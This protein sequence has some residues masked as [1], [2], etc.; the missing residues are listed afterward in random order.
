MELD[1][2]NYKDYI[3]SKM[4]P[5]SLRIHTTL[6]NAVTDDQDSDYGILAN[7][8]CISWNL[9][10]NNS[11]KFDPEDSTTANDIVARIMLV[12]KKIS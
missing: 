10:I 9:K 6:I 3:V 7:F 1:F 4:I 2:R 5:D 11:Y 8:I 12:I